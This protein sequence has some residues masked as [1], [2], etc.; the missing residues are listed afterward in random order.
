MQSVFIINPNASQEMIDN[1]INERITMSAALSQLVAVTIDEGNYHQLD[2]VVTNAI[3]AVE[4]FIVEAKIL[5][6]CEQ[7]VMH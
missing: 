7:T 2:K 5:L 6:G 4:H 3:W 1:A